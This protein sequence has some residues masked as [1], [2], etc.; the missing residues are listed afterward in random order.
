[1]DMR[2][3]SKKQKIFIWFPVIMLPLSNIILAI[4]SDGTYVLSIAWIFGAT[5]EELFFRFFL[6]RQI[7]F[8]TM[9]SVSSILLVSILFAGM[10]LFNLRTGQPV[11]VTLLQMFAAFCFS[12][13]AG[14]VTWKTTWLIPL[15][16][17]ILM[18]ATAEAEV[19]CVQVLV[20]VAVLVDGMFLMRGENNDLPILQ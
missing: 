1:M 6:L 9:K 19:M 20:S 5:A 3:L 14:A 10:H 16:A 17:H 7:L 15:I 2:G 18:N 4:S 13:W 11:D 12:I 8:R